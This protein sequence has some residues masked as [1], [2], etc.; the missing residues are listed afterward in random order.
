MD[1]NQSIDARERVRRSY[2]KHKVN[3]PFDK[4]YSTVWDGFHHVVKAH[5]FA[6][7]EEFLANKWLEEQC[8]RIITEEADTAVKTENERRRTNNQLPMDRTRKTGEQLEFE[9]PYYAGWRQKFP[10]VVKKY[11]LYGGMVEEY[12][13]QYLPSVAPEN[14]Q[15]ARSLIEDLS[16]EPVAPQMAPAPK[17]GPLEPNL[18][19]DLQSKD[20]FSLRKIARERGIETSK[21]DKKEALI[22]MLTQ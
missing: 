18:V 3:N 16:I 17:S 15:I 21:T 11:G 2:N 5:S 20:V 7:L 14:R 13:M 6:I 9:S 4:D 19:G 22:R 1:P 12:G 8:I 10:E